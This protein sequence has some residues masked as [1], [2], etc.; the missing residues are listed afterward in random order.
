MAHD[1]WPFQDGALNHI[2]SLQRGLAKARNVTRPDSHVL[3]MLAAFASM[4]T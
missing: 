1:S 2:L 3:H 4:I